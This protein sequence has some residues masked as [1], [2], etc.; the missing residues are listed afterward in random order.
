MI[1]KHIYIC[2][3]VYLNLNIKGCVKYFKIFNSK[4]SFS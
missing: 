1:L 2:N 3:Q 4:N